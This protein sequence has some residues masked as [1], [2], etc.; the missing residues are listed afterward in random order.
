[1][2]NLYSFIYER[3]QLYHVFLIQKI[4]CIVNMFLS[5][6]ETSKPQKLNIKRK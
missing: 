4:V 1:M 6:N 5:I 2:Y 3:L